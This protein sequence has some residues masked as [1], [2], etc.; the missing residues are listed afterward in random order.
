ML[1]QFEQHGIVNVLLRMLLA[2]RVRKHYVKHKLKQFDPHL[3]QLAQIGCEEG[4]R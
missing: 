1:P 3:A 4:E 2:F